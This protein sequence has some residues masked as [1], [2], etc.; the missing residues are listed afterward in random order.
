[1]PLMIRRQAIG[2]L[3]IGSRK[4]DGYDEEELKRVQQAATLLASSIEVRRQISRSQAALAETQDHARRLAALSEMGQSLSFASTEE[5]LFKITTRY[6]SKI[7]PA[8]RVSIALLKPNGSSLA[9]YGLRRSMGAVQL[10]ELSPLAGTGPGESVLSRSIVLIP[11]LAKSELREGARLAR[12]GLKSCLIAPMLVGERV[13]GTVNVASSHADIYAKREEDLLLHLASFIGVTLLNIRRTNELQRAKEAAELARA[14][15]ETANRE[16]SKFLA[17]MS[18]ELRTPLNGI[19]G[20]AQILE[21]SEL[22]ELQ[23][24]GIDVIRRSGEHLLSLINDILDIA[25]IE[26]RKLSLHL[27]EFSLPEMLHSVSEIFRVRAG[28]KEITFTYKAINTLPAVV[29]GDEQRLRQVLLNLL[30][31]ATKFTQAGG[32]TFTV[33]DLGELLRFKVE[34]TGVGI[35]KDDLSVIFE[36]F[37]QVGVPDHMSQG[38]GLGLAI[39]RELVEIMRGELKVQSRVGQGSTF[40][41][42]ISLPASERE[43]IVTGATVRNVVGYLGVPRRLIVADDVWENRSTLV[44]MLAPLGFELHEAEH[45]LAV[46]AK[47]QEFAPDLVLL[48]LKMPHMD[49]LETVRAMRADPK[50]KQIKIVIISASAFDIDRKESLEAGANGFIAKPFRMSQLLDIL[51][52]TLK[53]RWTYE[54]ED[55]LVTDTPTLPAAASTD[56][57][58]LVLPPIE[59]LQQLFDL[60]RRGDI[61]AVTTLAR[62][63][64]KSDADCAPFTDQIIKLA[65]RFKLKELRKLLQQTIDTVSADDAT[66][67][68]D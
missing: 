24:T 59:S 33:E 36:P 31:N 44:N 2:T 46:L 52:R 15:A 8:D 9:L 51:G 58:E 5:E 19:L 53:L 22:S 30:G 48:D 39:S 67:Q 45:G 54:G 60:I 13:L 34:D 10:G 28:L 12:V 16:K 41:F 1:V 21:R 26:N 38:T 61:Q 4:L 63:L 43:R 23:T 20:Y 17:R 29:K 6:T 50:H 18:H 35:A 47:C 14:S 11:D 42:D 55:G 27:T 64:E 32:V 68:G 66:T 37:R 7:L 3:N 25:K 49:G 57:P 56:E 40:W 62:S 65:R